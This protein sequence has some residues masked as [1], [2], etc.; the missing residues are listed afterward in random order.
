MSRVRSS[1]ISGYAT[2]AQFWKLRPALKNWIAII[3]EFVRR[4]GE[5]PY[6]FSNYERVNCGLLAAGFWQAR[7]PVLHETAVMRKGK[8]LFGRADLNFWLGRTEYFIEAKMSWLNLGVFRD[9]GSAAGELDRRLER[10]SKDSRKYIFSPKD[11]WIATVFVVPSVPEKEWG[12]DLARARLLA[13][14]VS[15]VRLVKADMK[16]WILPRGLARWRA[17]E[18]GCESYCYYPAVAVLGRRVKKGKRRA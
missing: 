17:V 13:E 11:R 12:Q 10:A 14:F 4:R 2:K 3:D 5:P 15:A 7:I 1:C 8:R 9:V 6:V 16:A 18:K